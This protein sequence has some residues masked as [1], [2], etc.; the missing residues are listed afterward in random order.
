MTR[1]ELLGKWAGIAH[2]RYYRASIK[3]VSIIASDL[4]KRRYD[5][6]SSFANRRQFINQFTQQVQLYKIMND[7]QPL[8]KA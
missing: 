6:D 2:A 7:T 8:I 3:P 4:F 1:F 5:D